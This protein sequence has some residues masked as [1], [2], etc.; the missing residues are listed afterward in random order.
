[1]PGIGVF[2][3]RRE[4]G[5]LAADLH[6]DTRQRSGTI[7]TN[8]DWRDS[9]I[10]IGDVV[11]AAG[12]R[13]TIKPGTVVAFDLE[14][15]GGGLDA[16]RS[17][18]V[19]DGKLIVGELGRRP[20]VFTS[21]APLPRRGDWYGIVVHFQGEI[22]IRNAL[23][24]YAHEGISGGGWNR[25]HILQAVT[26]RQARRTGIHLVRMRQPLTLSELEVSESGAGVRIQGS[27]PVRVTDS[28]FADNATDGF[29]QIGGS[30]Q[31]LNSEFVDNG[32]ENADGANVV[33]ERTVGRIADNQF[34][35]GVGIRIIESRDLAVDGNTLNRHT[36]GLLSSNSLPRVEGNRMVA[37]ELAVRVE[38]PLV[39]VRVS[40]NTVE[41]TERLLDNQ[42]SRQVNAANNWWGG[43]DELSIGQRMDGAVEWR[44]FLNFDPSLPLDFAL[45]PN[46]PNPFNSGT[47]IEYTVGT[48]I[49]GTGSS[50]V[51][52]IFTITG[53]L[54]RRLVDEPTLPGHHAVSWDGRDRR[55]HAVASA[56]YFY[57]LRIGEHTETRRLLLLK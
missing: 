52:D 1:M 26:V 47:T 15:N 17:E 13:L 39:T 21:A 5:L 30:L 16:E 45:K 44:P 38:G 8:E 54:I 31:L 32:I 56:V 40:L 3:I 29:V 53:S 34:S 28:R 41:D 23:I 2:N 22:D 42:A 18:L 20:V 57:R 12:A 9:I 33:L 51:L 4:D 24:E 10:V 49:L 46:Y 7:E 14:Y 55:G 25:P 35:G 6:R 19:I 48:S 43:E 36:V 11:V 50:T 37:N 27:G